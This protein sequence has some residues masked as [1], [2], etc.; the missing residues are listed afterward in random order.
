MAI[1]LKIKSPVVTERVGSLPL[2]QSDD[3]EPALRRHIPLHNVTSDLSI[4]L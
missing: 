2:S 4:L 3:M 1:L